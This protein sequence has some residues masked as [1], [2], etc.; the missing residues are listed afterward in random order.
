MKVFLEKFKQ[1]IITIIVLLI[2]Y[3]GYLFVDT[4]FVDAIGLH[5]Y[6]G[7][8]EVKID[9]ICTIKVPGRWEVCEEN[10]M[11]YFRDPSIKDKDTN[12]VMIESHTYPM[13]RVGSNIEADDE[14]AES[15]IL[16]QDFKCLVQCNGVNNAVGSCYGEVVISVDNTPYFEKCIHALNDNNEEDVYFYSWNYCIDDKLLQKIAD[17][18]RYFD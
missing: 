9:D 14:N 16:S 8:Q 10:G 17:S 1:P 18:V 13:S 7:W 15:N 12:I 3:C 2:L 4:I 11:V 6:I 5:F